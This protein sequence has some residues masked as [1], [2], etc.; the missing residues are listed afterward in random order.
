MTE[1]PS[2]PSDGDVE[3]AFIYET[4]IETSPQR[5]W[6]ALT[7][8]EETRKY[9][10]DRRIT[11][12]WTPGSPVRFFEGGSDTVTDD[13]E[14][15]EAEPVRRLS[16]TFR[17]QSEPGGEPHGH[18][19]RVAWDIEPVDA[20]RTRLRLVH[21]QLASPDDVDDWQGGWMP[22]LTGLEAHLEGRDVLSPPFAPGT[23]H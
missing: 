13:G 2:V 1:T 7:S 11:S 3:P 23:Y 6:E 16:Y 12:D 4:E 15:L 17:N 21:D 10:F 9:W 14:V 20:A 22:I 5:L 18:I 19:T 8:G